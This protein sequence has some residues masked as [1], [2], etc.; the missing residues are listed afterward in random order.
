MDRAVFLPGVWAGSSLMGRRNATCLGGP[1]RA[2]ISD[3]TRPRMSIFQITAFG[4]VLY[5]ALHAR[6]LPMLSTLLFLCSM[7]TGFL[8]ILRYLGGNPNVCGVF[9]YI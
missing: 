4:A 7:G 1:N 8:A 5:H 2:P 3:P 9:V 6:A